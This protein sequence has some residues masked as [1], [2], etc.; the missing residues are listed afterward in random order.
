[1]ADIKDFPVLF[2]G[3]ADHIEEGGQPFPVGPINIFQFSQHKAHIF[4]PAFTTNNEWVFAVRKELLDNM[5]L[6]NL[7]LLIVDEEDKL[8]G[9]I[10]FDTESKTGPYEKP[11]QNIPIGTIPIFKDA[12]FMLLHFKIDSLVTHPG[13]YIVSAKLNSEHVKIGEAFFH[14]NP[15]PPLTT[16]QIEAIKSDPNSAKAIRIELGCKLCPTKL[17]IYT[18]LERQ[19]SLEE[20]GS[21][22][23]YN[24]GEEFKCKCGKTQYSLKYIKESFHGLLL[25]RLS[26]ATEGVS[27]VRRYAHEQVVDILRKFNMMLEREKEERPIQEFI[28]KNPIIL[29]QFHAKRLYIKPNILG[30][31]ETDFAILD[32]SDRLLLIELEKPSLRLF[33]KDGHPTAKL[34]HAYGQ[35]KDWLFEYAKYPAAV[36]EGLKLKPEQII[37]VKGVVIAGRSTQERFISMQRHMSKPPYP[38]VEFLTIDDLSRSLLEISRSLA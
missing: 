19:S 21:I 15:A 8:F 38:D 24:V 27:Y 17:N 14:Y 29:A 18:G 1:M 4:Y 28:E 32:T 2:L 22:W 6:L 30:K 3:I 37:S 10:N 12:P 16:D 9:K 13:K 34:M 26:L 23:E 36:L 33:K 25:K 11:L 20:E 5:S 31:F 35:V 7:E